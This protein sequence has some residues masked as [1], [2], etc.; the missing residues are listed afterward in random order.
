MIDRSACGTK[1]NTAPEDCARAGSAATKST[2]AKPKTAT[3]FRR[4]TS[5]SIQAVI[6][7]SAATKQS[8]SDECKSARDCFASLAMTLSPD[9]RHLDIEQAG[10]VAAED[11]A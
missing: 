4:D 8:R 10:G 9:R 7:R 1:R 6:A 5:S 3:A 2:A 11:R